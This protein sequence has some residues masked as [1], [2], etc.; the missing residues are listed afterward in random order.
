MDKAGATASD[1]WMCNF[2]LCNFNGIRAKVLGSIFIDVI[3]E[4]SSS[5]L[6]SIR[7]TRCELW[8]PQRVKASLRLQKRSRG[9]FVKQEVT[10]H[11]SDRD[12]RHNT[13]SFFRLLWRL[14]RAASV[15]QW[16]EKGSELPKTQLCVRACVHVR[17]FLL[18][19]C[20]WCCD[21][22]RTWQEVWNRRCSAISGVSVSL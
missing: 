1:L 6:G 2:I 15:S 7:A 17:L 21:Q 22:S 14:K 3:T 12:A 16:T 11:D 13:L 10:R 4:G 9:L 5:S 20:W 19:L 18:L 8:A